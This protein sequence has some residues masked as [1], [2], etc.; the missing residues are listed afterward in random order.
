MK[1]RS[2]N[3]Y[4]T[5][6]LA[7]PPALMGQVVHFERGGSTVTIKTPSIERVGDIHDDNAL[8]TRGAWNSN[9]GEV[10]H[11]IVRAVDVHVDANSDISVPAEVLQRRPNAYE[12]IPSG[13]QEELK[14]TATKCTE[15]ADSAI[16]YWVSLL[17]WVSGSHRICRDARV[18]NS[19]GWATYLADSATGSDV[20]T[21]GQTFVISGYATVTERA[22][23]KVNELAVAGVDPPIYA[24]LLGD[25]LDCVDNGDFRRALVDLSVS[26]EVF[27][28]TRVIASL[29]PGTSPQVTRMIEEAN[30]N[31]LVVRLFPELLDQTALATFKA[32]IKDDLSSL[33]DKRNKLMHV[34]QLHGVTQE[35]CRRFAATA[36]HLFALS[37]E[38]AL[39]GL[40]A[41][42]EG[43]DTAFI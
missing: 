32:R 6:A 28:R 38:A 21:H 23:A 5:R 42:D 39:G 15:C 31:Q 37:P 17:R 26:C 41:I 43:A 11:Y 7:I 14:Q 2:W 18:G 20:W 34:A 1:L 10:L 30:I 16:E 9:S 40:P 22:W 3:R 12:L 4:K 36:K 29:P 35:N 25:A 13:I 24:V 33:F 27:L 8:A 19:S